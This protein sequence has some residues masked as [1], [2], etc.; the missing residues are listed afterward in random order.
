L[1]VILEWFDGKDHATKAIKDN[2]II[3]E[4]L[5]EQRPELVSSSCV[6]SLVN[7]EIIRKR[8]TNEAWKATEIVYGEK[9][10][11]SI[12]ICETCTLDADTKEASV[13]CSSCL[14]LQHLSCARM[15]LFPKAKLWFCN[16]CKN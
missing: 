3:N 9:R 15:K 2:F 5:V 4:E 8:C 10:R 11:N 13:M 12:Y 6:D 14:E 1:N 16:K 7:I